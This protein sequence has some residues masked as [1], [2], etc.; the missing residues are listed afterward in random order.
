MG[1]FSKKTI[2]RLMYWSTRKI[3]DIWKPYG[4]SDYAH[5]R[6]VRTAKRGIERSRDVYK[7]EVWKRTALMERE[8]IVE[9]CHGNAAHLGLQNSRMET[10]E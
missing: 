4:T 1:R 8:K 5:R 9:I 2:Y 3:G 10:E 6:E 7:T